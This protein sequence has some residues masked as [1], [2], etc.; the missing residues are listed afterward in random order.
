MTDA[1]LLLAAILGP[2]LVGA[3]LLAAGRWR[4]IRWIGGGLVAAAAHGTAWW[5]VVLAYRGDP[6]AWRSFQPDLLRASVAVAAEVAVILAAVRAD[7]LG[8][9][10]PGATVGLAV[11]ASAVVGAAFS[12]SLPV[13]AVLL[14]IPTIAAAGAALTGRARAD[15]RGLLALA[16]ADA[17][18]LAGLSVVYHRVEA[19][20]VAPEGG[21][22]GVGLLLAA[23]AVKAGAVPGVGTWRLAGTGGPG[24]PVAVA[25][26]GQ[27]VL[28]AVVAGL[29]I[30]A[31][32]PQPV[33]AGVAA[34]A[35]LLA[36]AAAVGARTGTRA[37]AAVAGAGAGLPFVALGLGGAVGTR[38]ALIL[39]PP[40][41]L[42]AGAAFLLGWS[43]RADEVD[44]AGPPSDPRAGWRWL[45]ASAAAVGAVS[46]I[47][48][49][50]GGGFPG[51][52]LTLSL[53]GAR[54]SAAAPYLLV[55]GAAGLG[56]ALA[57]VGSVPLVRSVRARAG[58]AI[59]GTV[60]A[61]T[62]MYMG[63]QPVRLGIGWWLRIERELGTP[64][65]LGAS[66]APALP[67]V[68]GLN[69]AVVMVEAA[70]LVGLV[71]LLGRGFRDSRAPFVPL[72][73]PGRAPSF[74][75]PMM[76]AGRLGDRARTAEVIM[77]AAAVAEAGAV[78]LAARLVILSASRGFL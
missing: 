46:V 27:G 47:G 53:A 50:P 61:A 30:G 45:G 41:L 57:A 22:L 60:A 11:A 10:S 52:W 75:A 33:V 25:L 67:P 31:A 12:Q 15:L 7:R 29:E 28:L 38:A 40:I 69:V 74:L 6:P 16:A 71:V 3:V 68:G 18:A 2:A 55:A 65:V 56:L 72:R 48:L 58:P 23:A 39:V 49:P 5:V 9:W 66:G 54:S 44:P 24:A 34:G 8:R 17:V 19:T 42:G 59:L 14:P 73:W 21:V 70:L 26:R 76:G 64:E 77:A 13:L 1:R 78:V 51:A 62:L 20:A 36:G 37:A 35:V 43:P 4:W 32:Q 63:L